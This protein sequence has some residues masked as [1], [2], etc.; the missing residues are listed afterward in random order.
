MAGLP[1]T[2]TDVEDAAKRIVPYVHR[3]PVIRSRAID[4]AAGAELHLKAE[5]LQR[6][7]AFKAR[8]AYNALL[9]LSDEQRRQGVLAVSSGNHAQAIAH[10]AS[11]L[12][13]EATVLVPEGSNPQKI[14]AARAYGAT[15]V[16][17]GITAANREAKVVEYRDG[18]GLH[19]VHPFD[20]TRVM[21]GQGTA[22]L[23][24]TD[25]SAELDAV[26]T[27]VG[28]GGLLS[29]VATAVKAR[30]PKAKVY[31]VEPVT[32]DDCHRSMRAGERVFLDGPP[33]TIC[34]GVRA[35]GVG[36]RTWTVI[37]ALVDDVVTVTDEQVLDA[38]WL[39][40]SRAKTV[41]EPSGALPLAAVLAGEIGGE[42]IGVVLSGGNVDPSVLSRLASR[43]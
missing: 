14:I 8:G 20:D 21:A 13:V 3:T 31:G 23:E 28:G 24:L 22:G 38:M 16:S 39:L 5:N 11:A 4:Y 17:E 40:Y 32:A 2:I 12:R 19:L 7:G 43:A 26:V 41:V 1:I 10:A 15:V 36:E 9:Q 42:R 34:D 6:T 37:Q 29:G 27:P 35:L 18:R 30:W 25:Q 33:D